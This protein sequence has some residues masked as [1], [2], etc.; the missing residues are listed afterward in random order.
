MSRTTII[1]AVGALVLVFGVFLVL[2]ADSLATH[3]Q[4]LG[5][6]AWGGTTDPALRHTYQVF[7]MVGFCF[8]AGLLGIA[9]WHW[10]AAEWGDG[11]TQ[12]GLP[13]RCV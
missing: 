8:G 4:P 6:G 9:A 5:D 7:G 12:R 1:L 2:R 11:R 3:W 13:A 10:L